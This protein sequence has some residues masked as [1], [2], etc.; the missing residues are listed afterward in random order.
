MEEEDKKDDDVLKKIQNDDFIKGFLNSGTA[1]SVLSTSLSIT[2]Q[3][4]KLGEAID[5][6]NRE[7]QKQVLEKHTDLLQQASHATKLEV[8]LNTMNMHV[9]SLFA[10]AERL[11]TQISVPYNELEKHTVVLGRLHLASHI[12]RQ[13]NR[14]QQLS[15][16][17]SCTVDPV[18]KAT[19]LQELEN[20]ASDPELEDID[21]VTTELRNIRAQQQ[22]IVQMAN[23]SLH[24]GINHENVTQTTTALQI[25]INLGMIKSTIDSFVEHS[26]YECRE[27]W[28]SAFEVSSASSKTKGGSAVQLSFSQGFRSKTWTELEKVFSEDIYQTCKHVKFLQN[29]LN[30]VHVQ[31]VQISFAKKFWIDFG[32][33]LEDDIGKTSPAVQQMLEEDYPKLLRCYNTLIKK[34]KYD[35]F[36]YDSKVLKKLES[37]YLSTSLAKMLDPTQSMFSNEGVIP[38]H[39]QIDSLIRILTRSVLRILWKYDLIVNFF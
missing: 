6:L 22:K 32:K 23:G 13:V 29:T 11:K 36:V 28:K 9:Q 3:V 16:R 10:N 15:K 7:L 39:D 24:Q 34:L 12:L 35:Y 5:Q 4:K 8:V 18:Q 1:K 31:N 38:T 25:F 17:L 33:F 21:A 37:S 30:N 14:L 26:L 20:L 19:I 27:G 2:E